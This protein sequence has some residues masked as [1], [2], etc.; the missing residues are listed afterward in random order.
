MRMNNRGVPMRQYIPLLMVVGIVPVVGTS[1]THV[2]ARYAMVDYD[3]ELVDESAEDEIEASLYRVRLEKS[4][5]EKDDELLGGIEVSFLREDEELQARP[6]RARLRS[7]ELFPYFL[8]PI[9]GGDFRASTRF[10]LSWRQLEYDPAGPSIEWSSLGLKLLF[11]PD[12]C[13]LRS[14]E[15]DES[16]SVYGELGGTVSA[17]GA[18]GRGRLVQVRGSC[19]GLPGRAWIAISDW[20]PGR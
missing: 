18:E 5:R 20:C 12:V 6:E 13:L 19:C 16:L 7:Y 10:G 9:E 14:R 8:F 11:E 17:A 4:E 1:C 2:A 3:F 15:R